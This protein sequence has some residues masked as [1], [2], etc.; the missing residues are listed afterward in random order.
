MNFGSDGILIFPRKYF[1]IFQGREGEKEK[2]KKISIDR[3]VCFIGP[4]LFLVGRITR[5]MGAYSVITVLCEDE[6]G[7]R[8]RGKKGIIEAL[9][10]IPRYI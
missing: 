7:K 10:I 9:V 1:E 6:K 3:Y 2:K 8:G 5:K 4:P